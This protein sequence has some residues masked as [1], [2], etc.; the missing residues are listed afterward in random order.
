[1]FSESE[2]DEFSLSNKKF[3]R[4][5]CCYNRFKS[6]QNLWSIFLYKDQV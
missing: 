1:V 3:N 6:W 5:N 2:V 4:F